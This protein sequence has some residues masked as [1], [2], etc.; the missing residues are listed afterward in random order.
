MH[1]VAEDDE[2]DETGY[3]DDDDDCLLVAVA[4]EPHLITL[5]STIVIEY[6]TVQK[7]WQE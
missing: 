6:I 5:L 4:T 2:D 7:D 1:C 3:D